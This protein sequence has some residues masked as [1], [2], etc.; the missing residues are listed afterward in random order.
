MLIIATTA[1]GC[2]VGSQAA[3]ETVRVINPEQCPDKKLVFYLNCAGYYIRPPKDRP[4][5]CQGLKP[6]KDVTVKTIK[7]EIIMESKYGN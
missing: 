4:K 1:E 2:T 5:E 3:G 7:D 6:D